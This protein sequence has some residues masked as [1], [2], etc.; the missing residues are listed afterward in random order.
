MAY[1]QLKETLRQSE[2]FEPEPYRDRLGKLTIGYG[3]LIDPKIPGSKPLPPGVTRITR[4]VAEK[5]LDEDIYDKLREVQASSRAE[6]FT[7][8]DDARQEIVLDC[9]FQLG[10]AGFGGWNKCWDA[11]AAQDWNEAAYQLLDSRAAEQT[12]GRF[13]ERAALM[14]N[15]AHPQPDLEMLPPG[16]KSEQKRYADRTRAEGA[17]ALV[18]N[19]ETE[20]GPA[21]AQETIDRIAAKQAVHEQK[22]KQKQDAQMERVDAG[23]AVLGD[24]EY[25][26]DPAITPALRLY[27]AAQRLKLTRTI[28]PFSALRPESQ[29]RWALLARELGLDA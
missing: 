21:M 10:V 24:E 18:L 11:L 29:V 19:S 22:Q 17:P 5:W 3:R 6:V 25:G 14:R 28:K 4:E 13:F 15:T 1:E 26:D 8:L 2:G 7:A 16:R 12:T 27:D 23:P 9:C 20:G